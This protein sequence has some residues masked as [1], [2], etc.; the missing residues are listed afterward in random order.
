MGKQPLPAGPGT[1]ARPL[2][3]VVLRHPFLLPALGAMT[4]ARALGFLAVDIGGT[5]FK[6]VTSAASQAAIP[7]FAH[8]SL[9]AR[10]LRPWANWDGA[11]YISIA[12]HGYHQPQSWAFFPFYPSLLRGTAAL[13]DGDY[14][15]AGVAVSMVAALAAAAVLYLLVEDD[16]GP[17]VALWTV[18]FLAFFPTSFFLQAVYTESLFLLM[19]VACVLWA[20]RG[21]W[22]LAGLAGMLAALTRNTGIL[23]LIPVL[24]LTARR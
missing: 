7:I 10:L 2:P 11:W 18:L 19:S 24:G 6:P 22:E 1:S 12:S 14:V 21:R 15:L 3:A 17:R 8:D 16:H 9:L 20:R 5:W 23:L 13:T 4:A